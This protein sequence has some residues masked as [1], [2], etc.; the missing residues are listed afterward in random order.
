MRAGVSVADGVNA[1][2]AIQFVLSGPTKLF[3]A[4][5]WQ[6]G[7]TVRGV[8]PADRLFPGADGRPA[9]GSLGVL[10]DEVVGY[11]IIGSLPEGAW[12]VSTEIWIDI[13]RPLAD[14]EGELSASARSIA[15]GSFATG[16]L[17]DA[18]GNLIAECRERG[19]EIADPPDFA[20]ARTDF[21]FDGAVDLDQDLSGVLSLREMGEGWV[22]P[23]VPRWENP[24]GVLHGGISLAASEA[25][26]TASRVEAGSDLATSSLHIVHTRAVPSGVDLE[27]RTTTR[28]AGRTLWVTDVDAV[29]N[30]KVCATTRVSAQA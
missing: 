28:H 21:A 11:S 19:R 13:V 30:G 9:V 7:D 1:L 20:V 27:L 29:W 23:V 3:G 17:I 2:S 18:S 10:V 5:P 25:A 26:A 16:E 24:R 4:G 8:M 22:L 15:P 12:T 6:D 14:A